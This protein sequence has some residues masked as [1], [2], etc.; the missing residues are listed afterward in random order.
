MEQVTVVTVKVKIFKNLSTKVD[1]Y[2]ADKFKKQISVLIIGLSF[3]QNVNSTM[4][5]HILQGKYM[6]KVLHSKVLKD[7]STSDTICLRS[8]KLQ[9]PNFYFNAIF[10][11]TFKILYLIKRLSNQRQRQDIT[12]YI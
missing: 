6:K 9:H 8:M 4:S 3:N 7:V 2:L 11:T 1:G 12:V 10:L 5:K